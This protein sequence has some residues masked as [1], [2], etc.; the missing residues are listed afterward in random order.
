LSSRNQRRGSRR[1]GA[2]TQHE[3]KRACAAE[4]PG[5]ESAGPRTRRGSGGARFGVGRRRR[6]PSVALRG[7]IEGSKEGQRHGSLRAEEAGD[8]DS[9]GEET[10]QEPG[11]EDEVDAGWVRAPA[12]R[13]AGASPSREKSRRRGGSRTGGAAASPAAGGVG[14]PTARRARQSRSTRP[15]RVRPDPPG[16]FSAARSWSRLGPARRKRAR[17]RPRRGRRDPRRRS[18]TTATRSFPREENR[19]AGAG[20][21]SPR[22]RR[23]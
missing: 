10:G 22:R 17:S 1:P 23:S 14:D 12:S 7:L 18:A 13:E 16:L 6:G 21:D 15:S 2:V 8:E 9:G 4:S 11:Q 19:S 3:Q 20:S 5:T